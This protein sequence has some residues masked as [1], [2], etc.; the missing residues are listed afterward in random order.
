M[1]RKIG[2][3]RPEKLHETSDSQFGSV[4]F[5]IKINTF[6]IHGR[7][8]IEKLSNTDC[9]LPDCPGRVLGVS[10]KKLGHSSGF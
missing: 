8:A 10:C 4:F 2:C 5:S 1:P 3:L 9:V 6:L 7:Y